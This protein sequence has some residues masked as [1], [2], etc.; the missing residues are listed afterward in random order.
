MT[1]AQKEY[2]DYYLESYQQE[3]TVSIEDTTQESQARQ[4]RSLFES[5]VELVE[6]ITFKYTDVFH[7]EIQDLKRKIAKKEITSFP[8]VEYYTVKES[9]NQVCVRYSD[10]K[11][12]IDLT[13]YSKLDS[14][15]SALVSVSSIDKATDFRKFCLFAYLPTTQLFIQYK[16]LPYNLIQSTLKERTGS[17]I[18][19]VFMDSASVFSTNGFIYNQGLLLFQ[20]F[21]HP[22]FNDDVYFTVEIE[23]ATNGRLEDHPLIL[24]IPVSAFTDFIGAPRII[25]N[26][27]KEEFYKIEHPLLQYSTVPLSYLGKEVSLINNLIG[28]NIENL[29]KSNTRYKLTVYFDFTKYMSDIPE[30][31]VRYYLVLNGRSNLDSDDE[32]KVAK[33]LLFNEKD[34]YLKLE[35]L[36]N[37]YKAILE[38]D[39]KDKASNYYNIA[40]HDRTSNLIQL[41]EPTEIQITDSSRYIKRF[42]FIILAAIMI[43]MLI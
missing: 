23:G 5:K 24:S 1:Y 6:I 28:V 4:M 37:D 38:F 27:F 12:N 39:E 11:G 13:Q 7:S 30:A 18:N 10:V 3:F 8:A 14:K 21:K 41:Y 17:G 2:L 34:D 26:R 36:S 15:N 31:D 40:A 20:I 32:F 9:S 22:T 35:E 29:E 19:E 16:N 33:Y 25:I 43:L 42:S